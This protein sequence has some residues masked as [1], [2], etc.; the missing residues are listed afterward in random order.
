[1]GLPTPSTCS[2]ATARTAV[3]VWLDIVLCFMC[4][5]QN[6]GRVTYFTCNSILRVSCHTQIGH[7]HTRYPG[8]EGP[9]RRY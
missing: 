5:I 7:K 6:N 9:R 2:P 8:H 1:M 4:C 3:V